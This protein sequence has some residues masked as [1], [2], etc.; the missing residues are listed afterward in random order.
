MFGDLLRLPPFPLWR[1]EAALCPKPCPT[2]PP[3]AVP[4]VKEE[5]RATEQPSAQQNGLSAA[6]VQVQHSLQFRH[7]CCGMCS[8][9][10]PVSREMRMW[11]WEGLGTTDS[12]AFQESPSAASPDSMEPGIRDH[13]RRQHKRNK[14]RALPEADADSSEGML[15]D[16][17]NPAAHAVEVAGPAPVLLAVALLTCQHNLS[18]LSSPIAWYLSKP[19]CVSAV[20][21]HQLCHAELYSPSVLPKDKNLRGDGL[22]CGLPAQAALGWALADSW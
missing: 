5:A 1:L 6:A 22:L 10:A 20:S 14:R 18:S 8:A 3:P 21:L 9:P 11:S 4:A 15:L 7:T 2:P 19:G 16:M 17:V 12:V 13:P